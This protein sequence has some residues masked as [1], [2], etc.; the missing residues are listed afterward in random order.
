MFENSELFAFL[1]NST[2][3]PLLFL[4]GEKASVS[5]RVDVEGQENA[6]HRSEEEEINEDGQDRGRRR[7]KRRRMK[8]NRRQK[9]KQDPPKQQWFKW[10]SMAICLCMDV[11]L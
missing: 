6:S 2:W 4:L 7:Q 3:L 5:Q 1:S 10:I 8:E 11:I 9:V